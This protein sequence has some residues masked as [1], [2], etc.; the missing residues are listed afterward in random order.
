MGLSWRRCLPRF[1]CLMNSAIPPLYLNSTDLASPVLG[2]VVRSSVSVI[3]R[4]LFRKASSRRRWARVSK[5]YSVTVKM[6]LSGRKWTL[7]PVLIFAAP[8]FFSLLVG[9][10]LEYVCSQVNP[11]RQISSSSSSLRA[12]TQET[13]TPCS[14]PETLYVEESNL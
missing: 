6:L 8:V 3:W 2:S 14:P 5:L 11:S 13:P 10:P 7:V 12:F 9:S 1:R 4:P